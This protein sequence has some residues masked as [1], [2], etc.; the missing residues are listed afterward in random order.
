M[1]DIAGDIYD[2]PI[3][4]SEPLL[5]RGNPI[6]MASTVMKRSVLDEA[7]G[8]PVEKNIPSLDY[9]LWIRVSDKHKFF[10]FSEALAHYRVLSDSI[11]HG[12]FEKEYKAQLGI[13]ERH[14]E[15]YTPGQYRKRLAWLYHD[16][17]DSAFYE[18]DFSGW[19]PWRK[20]IA[21]DPLN[22]RCW[23]LGGVA[24]VKWMI[25]SCRKT[26]SAQ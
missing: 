24:M 21:L 9:D 1:K 19:M 5:M 8:F 10:V 3:D 14:K 16:W 25:A 12:S 4:L 26:V 15:R 20:S 22:W 2:R 13:I 18:G 17:A 7:G 11:L 23:R 6:F